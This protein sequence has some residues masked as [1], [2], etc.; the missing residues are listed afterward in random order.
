MNN[1]GQNKMK[2]KQTTLTNGNQT[3]LERLVEELGPDTIKKLHRAFELTCAALYRRAKERAE[4]EIQ[5]ADQY[6]SLKEEAE[7]RG[8]L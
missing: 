5:M 3:H 1:G 8:K 7:Q 4:A 2:K 6:R